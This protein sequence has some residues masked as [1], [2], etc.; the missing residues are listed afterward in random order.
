MQRCRVLVINDYAHMGGAEVVYQQSA[1][2]L[3]TLRG[4]EVERFDDSQFSGRSTMLTRSWNTTA[5][6]AL[7]KTLHRFR[8][9]RLMVH[10]YHNVLSPSIL[11]VIARNQRQFGYRAYHT[12]HDYHLVYYNPSLQYFDKDKRPIILP[13]DVLRTRAVLTLRPTPKGLVHD[14]MTKAWWHA[15]RA[16]YQPARVFDRILCPS[17]FMQQALHRVGIENTVIVHNPS[18]VPSAMPIVTVR[19]KERFNIAFVGRI[20]PEKGLL[21]FL[22]LCEAAGFERINSIGVYG[23]GP[24]RAAIEQRYASLI[25]QRKLILFGTMPQQQLFPA[26][27]EFADAVVVPSVGAENAPLV[28][29]EAAMLGLPVLIRDGGSMAVTAESVGNKIKFKF[30]PGSLKQ[31]LAELAVHL[32]DEHRKYDVGEY[33]PEHYAQRLAE[34]MHIGESSAPIAPS[35]RR[36]RYADNPRP[37]P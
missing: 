20:S 34:I 15:V 10:N 18:A 32:A 36:A 28:V 3:G 4:V 9:H 24:D 29:V 2:L 1:E 37:A 17:L 27:R 30:D 25:A 16:A 14:L 33:L 6:R 31:A 7:E 22:T 35:R 13:L 23:D 26:M 5:A 21:Q 11:S 12:C 19:N 8:P